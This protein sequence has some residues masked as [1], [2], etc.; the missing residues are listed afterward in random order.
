[1]SEETSNKTTRFMTMG[2]AAFSTS[3]RPRL[4]SIVYLCSRAEIRRVFWSETHLVSS[5][6]G[7]I[8]ELNGDESSTDQ[9]VP[10][11][12]AVLARLAGGSRSLSARAG[13]TTKLNQ[14]PRKAFARFLELS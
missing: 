5:S 3:S 7:S 11:F 10:A 6:F 13:Q 2:M 4:L 1:M 8:I 14:D 12:A 9:E